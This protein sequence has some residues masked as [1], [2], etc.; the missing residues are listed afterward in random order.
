MESNPPFVAEP[1]DDPDK[2]VAQFFE[3]VSQGQGPHLS[4]AE[5]DALVAS[6][7]ADRDGAG[8]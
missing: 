2:T 4:P 5:H 1:A 6:I 7:R 3:E 8:D